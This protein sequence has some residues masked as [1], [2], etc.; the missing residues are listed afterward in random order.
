MLYIQLLLL[1]LKSSTDN[2][3]KRKSKKR[4][5]DKRG[6]SPHRTSHR[7]DIINSYLLTQQGLQAESQKFYTSLSQHNA[8]MI[9]S[10]NS[11]YMAA[12]MNL[13]RK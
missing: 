1:I 12:T 2:K 5:K 6:R 4:R 10:M 9:N 7:D 8:H 13:N 3:K 11:N